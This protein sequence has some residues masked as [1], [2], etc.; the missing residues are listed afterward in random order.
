MALNKNARE[1][2]VLGEA[3]RYCKIMAEK[4]KCVVVL[5]A[6]L[7]DDGKVMYSRAIAHH[8]SWWWKWQCSEED[9]QRG[10]V[11][12]EQGKARGAECYDFTLTTDFAHMQMNN[13]LANEGQPKLKR[14]DSKGG[15][16]RK[17][18]SNADPKAKVKLSLLE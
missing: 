13:E 7:N 14:E 11:T 2:Q 12:V 9:K 17:S 3:A 5:L 8:A 16:F 1:D 18:D 4:L 15:P 6:Q 10:F